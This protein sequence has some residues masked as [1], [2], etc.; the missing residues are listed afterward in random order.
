M[1]AYSNSQGGLKRNYKVLCASSHL[2]RILAHHRSN[3]DPTGTWGSPSQPVCILGSTGRWPQCRVWDQDATCSSS[4]WW[5][6]AAL[7]R[8]HSLAPLLALAPLVSCSAGMGGK[9]QVVKKGFAKI[10]RTMCYCGYI[11]ILLIIHFLVY[12]TF[13]YCLEQI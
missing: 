8:C 5:S 2:P 9:R 11:N 6:P 1:M 12:Q 4:R 3:W 13:F 7:S 10:V